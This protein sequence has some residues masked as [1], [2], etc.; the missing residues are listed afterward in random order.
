[1]GDDA[2]SS[3][4]AA[5][6]AVSC[7]EPRLDLRGQA[8]LLDDPREQRG[9]RLEEVDLGGLESPDGARLDVEDADDLVVPHERHR[10]HPGE[11][12]DVEAAHPREPRVA[13]DVLDRDRLAG[14]ATRPVMPSPQARLTEPTWLRSRPFV[15]ASVSRVFSWSAR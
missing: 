15:A 9:D 14:R 4:L 6:S 10:Q 7:G 11:A 5:S 13:G 2:S 8:A 12:F 1:M 3:A